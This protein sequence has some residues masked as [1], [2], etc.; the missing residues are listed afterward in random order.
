MT[1]LTDF[2]DL[3][4]YVWSMRRTSIGIDME[5]LLKAR[6]L[7]GLRTKQEIVN[8]ALELLVR[9][10]ARKSILRYYGSGIWKGD[11]KSR[12]NRISPSS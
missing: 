11:L 10:E 2:T 7:T 6:K 8:R 9:S 3:G 4:E 5:L 12:K 1:D